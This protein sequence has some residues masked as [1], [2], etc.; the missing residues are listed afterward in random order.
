MTHGPFIVIT[1]PHFVAGVGFKHG[2][3][4]EFPPIVKYMAGWRANKIE[5]YAESKGWKFEWID[6]RESP[7][8]T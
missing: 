4:W 2:I 6:P 8:D 3:A 1:A 5:A 7:N